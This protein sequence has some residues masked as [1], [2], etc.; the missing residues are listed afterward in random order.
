MRCFFSSRFSS[1]LDTLV[2][3]LFL[4]T[5]F[6]FFAPTF[7]VVGRPKVAFGR[8][9]VAFGRP[10]VGTVAEAAKHS[11]SNIILVLGTL[12]AGEAPPLIDCSARLPVLVLAS[13]DTCS[14]SFFADIRKTLVHLSRAVMGNLFC[15][16]LLWR[17]RSR[18]ASPSS[19]R[20]GHV[21]PGAATANHT[22]SLHP[23]RGDNSVELGDERIELFQI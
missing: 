14:L 23:N 12:L 16:F 22:L 1:F 3:R 10:K 13:T 11:K 5:L 2:V 17:C 4:D 15:R 19:G 8:P 18:L 20:D 7:R 21:C 9:K 6:F